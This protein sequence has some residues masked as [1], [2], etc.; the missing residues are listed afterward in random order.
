MRKPYFPYRKG[1]PQPLRVQIERRVRFEE[2]D[3]LGMVWHGRYASYFEDVRAAAGERYG[4]GYLDFYH[5]K[6]VAPVRIMHMDFLHP[7]RFNET[8]TIESILHWTE[9]TRINI[10]Y[11]IRNSEGSLATM[12]YTVQVLIDG[13]NNLL[14]IPPPFYREF[15]EKWR[16]GQL[17]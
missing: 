16:K 5:N 3:Q 2:V 6:V 14:L 10:E 15:R 9:A 13:E 4:I 12:G 11:I 17:A 7:L 1:D 8:I